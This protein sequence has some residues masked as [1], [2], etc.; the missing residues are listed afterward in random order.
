LPGLPPNRTLLVR[1][2]IWFH[3]KMHLF[4]LPPPLSSPFHED[5]KS[6]S[7]CPLFSIFRPTGMAIRK[8]KGCSFLI[9]WGGKRVKIARFML[10]LIRRRRQITKPVNNDSHSSG[11]RRGKGSGRRPETELLIAGVK[12]IWGVETSG[13]HWVGHD[14]RTLSPEKKK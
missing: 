4:R 8:R 2:L 10:L 7:D 11:W 13:Y 14:C 3:A 9:I 1:D 5:G 12:R 6:A